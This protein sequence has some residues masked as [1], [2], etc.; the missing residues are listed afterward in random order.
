MLENIHACPQRS[1]YSQSCRRGGRGGVTLRHRA[2]RHR[3]T[4]T[5]AGVGEDLDFVEIEVVDGV[6][7][8]RP[9]TRDIELAYLVRVR[10][11][12]LIND[13][14]ITMSNFDIAG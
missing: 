1:L 2:G 12:R 8:V 9:I 11:A 4:A 5:S 7:H 13:K 6:V 14:Q 3:S 10:C